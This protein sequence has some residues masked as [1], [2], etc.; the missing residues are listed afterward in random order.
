M[1]VMAR[2]PMN[3]DKGA[4]KLGAQRNSHEE[5]GQSPEAL[6]ERLCC[7]WN[8]VHSPARLQ[9]DSGLDGPL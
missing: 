5:G 8:R 3:G 9:G 7:I 2:G 1:T 6:C 4:I